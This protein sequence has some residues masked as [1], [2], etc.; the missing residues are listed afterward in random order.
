MFL[1]L[2]GEAHAKAL[3]AILVLENGEGS[4][5][6]PRFVSLPSPHC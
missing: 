1:V 6:S 3:F 5:V 4:G 2:E